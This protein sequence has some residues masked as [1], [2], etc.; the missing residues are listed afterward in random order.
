MRDSWFES[1]RTIVGD[2]AVSPGASTTP[3]AGMVPAFVVEPSDVESLR[4][5]LAWAFEHGA[6]V[7]PVGGGTTFD[8]G[9][10]P[11]RIDVALSTRRLDAVIEHRDADLTA[12]VQA[13]ASLAAVNRTLGERGQWIPLDPDQPERA[14]IGGVLACDASGPR[15]HRHG[16]PRDL[17]IGIAFVT[18]E[19]TLARAGGRVVKN[20]A[21]YDLGK[22]LSGSH[23]TLGVIVEATFKLTPRAP[24]SRT[25]EIVTPQSDRLADVIQTIASSQ[26]APTAVEIA[27]PPPTALVRF[28]SL[29]ASVV[30]QANEAVRLIT[31]H[32]ATG[33][34]LLGPA[35]EACWRNH[36]ARLNHTE[37][38]GGPSDASA[39][40]TVLNI[41][42]PPAG[43]GAELCWLADS[44]PSLGVAAELI[45]RAALGTL[46]LKLTGS[47]DAQIE[48]I[49]R[50]HDRRVKDGGH[51]VLTR[52]PDAVRAGT[53][54][55]GPLGDAARVMQAVKRSFD[56]QGVLSPGRWPFA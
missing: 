19:G 44:M 43:L 18:A 41:G 55:W 22:V 23:G 10:R 16:A 29:E 50:L 39:A 32:G 54:P 4:A 36:S 5:V 3:L 37:I 8:W 48:A 34:I 24:A 12:T 2:D 28:E 33:R 9:R 52:G 49:G 26:L 51:A 15:R 31:E 40:D 38:A 25:V 45:G 47:V 20:V 53:D 27:W 21:G 13:G 7:A 56:P 35:E 46:S 17:L 1:L 30:W 14:T 6:A 11:S 42:L